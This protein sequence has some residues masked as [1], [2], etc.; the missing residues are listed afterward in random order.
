MHGTCGFGVERERELLLPVEGVAGVADGVVAVLRAGAMSGDVG[1]VSSNLVGDHAVLD[2]LLVGQAEVLLGRD[3][4]K[5]GSPVPADHGCADSR[6]DVVVAGSDVG[7]Q[8][9]EGVEGRAEAVF[10][11]LVDLLLDLVEGNVA[12]T[13]D[14]DLYVALPGLG[15]EW[16]ML[17]GMMRRP[18]AISSRTSSAEMFSR[19]AT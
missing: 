5:H 14:H 4:A 6:G 17:A 19:R 2:V 18:A 7:D 13:F 10:D 9:P 16:L 8:R 15:S 1:G 11:P 12:G 3:V